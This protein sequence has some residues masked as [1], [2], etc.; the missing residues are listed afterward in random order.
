MSSSSSSAYAG[1][2]VDD[3]NQEE[4][5]SRQ[6]SLYEGP[7]TSS[8]GGLSVVESDEDSGEEIADDDDEMA[9]SAYSVPFTSSVRCSTPDT[10]P[11]STD[12]IRSEAAELNESRT[13][14][15]P[16][17]SQAD[18]N[19]R[20][21]KGTGSSPI[22]HSVQGSSHGATEA[23]KDIFKAMA[24]ELK[25]RWVGPMPIG[26]FLDEFLGEVPTNKPRESAKWNKVFEDMPSYTLESEMYTDVLGRLVKSK[27]MHTLKIVTTSQDSDNNSNVEMKNRP[28]L[29]IYPHSM[30][31]SKGKTQLD[32]MLSLF[33]IKSRKKA[34]NSKGIEV[35]RAAVDP[36]SDPGDHGHPKSKAKAKEGAFEPTA[37]ERTLCRGQLATYARM[38]LSRQHRTHFF[39]VYMGDPYAR[40]IRFDRDG[41]VVS[42]HFEY[43]KQGQ[44]L[45]E[46]L[47][48]LSHANDETRGLDPTVEEA[49][50]EEAALAREKLRKWKPKD[51]KDR[52]VYKLIVR[53]GETKAGEN[54]HPEPA[55]ERRMMKV[56]VWAA[57]AEP[58]CVVGRATQA[59][60][61]YDLASGKIV[62]VKDSWRA[63]DEGIE[64]EP[65]IL[66]AIHEGKPVEGVPIFLCGDDLEGRYQTT[67]TIL[68]AEK[69]WNIGGRP[70]N[71]PKKHIRFVTDKVGLP[72]EDFKCS[73]DF[74]KAVYD[75]FLAHKRVYLKCKILHRDVSLHNILVTEEG[76]GFL[77]DWDLAR[78]VE[79]IE[80]GPRQTARSGT[81]LYMS[82]TLLTYPTKFHTLQD[83]IEA[84]Y[85]VIVYVSIRYMSHN[86][87]GEALK[88]SHDYIFKDHRPSS[89]TKDQGGNGK[90]AYVENTVFMDGAFR[91]ARNA[92][93]DGFCKKFQI[94]LRRYYSIISDI[95][96]RTETEDLGE[97]T[98][99]AA[100][101]NMLFEHPGLVGSGLASHDVMESLFATAWNAQGWPDDDGSHDWLKDAKKKL[102]G[103]RKA[104]DEEK[105]T[106]PVPAEKA[107]RKKRSKT[108]VPDS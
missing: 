4:M 87:M 16:T 63:T 13:H 53:D 15:N 55:P 104:A 68:Y 54:P 73:K 39:A 84:F 106:L 66:K 38:V 98:E 21:A 35:L 32:V 81:W 102:S 45:C 43:R 108:S 85:W 86:Y 25:G 61:G 62:F 60:P 1:I 47:W 99:E 22:K 95:R 97:M 26:D 101:Y 83:D 6:A 75:A 100:A 42:A 24:K 57:L 11:H 79:E 107:P 71:S 46:F 77:N 92:L 31:E 37:Q 76:V 88:Q 89:G 48:R 3:P 103:K 93:L 90:R 96:R 10:H 69:S 80:S 36:F 28:D 70:V 7:G 20:S 41:A 9:P 91:L 94:C 14:S 72:I 51:D 65:E 2:D 82:A 33:E 56:L 23:Q 18:A 12:S 30:V 29:G 19:K 17:G 50:P 74:F 59:L 49:T 78:T 8:E 58:R 44:W 105:D 67:S 52:R 40:L 27:A 5:Y 34:K 64:K